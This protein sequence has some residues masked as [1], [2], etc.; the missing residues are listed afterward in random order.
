LAFLI[1]L[2]VYHR[3]RDLVVDFD[4]APAAEVRTQP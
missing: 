1:G 4:P 3:R 2:A